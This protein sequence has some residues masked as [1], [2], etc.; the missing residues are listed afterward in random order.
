MFFFYLL[1]YYS[2]SILYGLLKPERERKRDN[3][4]HAQQECVK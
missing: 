1:I 4:M 3:W 2:G